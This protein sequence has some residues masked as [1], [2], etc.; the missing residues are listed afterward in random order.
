[1][2]CD[3]FEF[4]IFWWYKALNAGMRKI[5]R[6]FFFIRIDSPLEC[7]AL[8]IVAVLRLGAC[9]NSSHGG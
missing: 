5:K 2:D 1:M 3:L 9:G 7:Y 4:T 8:Y 6:H